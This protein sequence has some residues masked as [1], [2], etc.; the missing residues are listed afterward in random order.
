MRTLSFRNINK[1]P[2]SMGEPKWQTELIK[3]INIEYAEQ[4]IK[5][6]TIIRERFDEISA[7]CLPEYYAGQ[8]IEILRT[9]PRYVYIKNVN[10]DGVLYD[11]EIDLALLTVEF[12][13]I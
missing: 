8:F 6:G 10:G 7:K 4:A 1:S 2:M 13:E 3:R 9:V 5:C 11:V 12:I